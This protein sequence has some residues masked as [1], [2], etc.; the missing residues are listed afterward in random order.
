MAFG[1]NHLGQV[2]GEAQTTNPDPN[3]EDFCGFA[4]LG[5]G[6]FRHYLCCRSCGKAAS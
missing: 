1:V 6:V 3:G 2:V 5:L 4:A